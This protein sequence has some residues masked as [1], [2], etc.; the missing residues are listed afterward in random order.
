MDILDD[1]D[2]YRCKLPNLN[3]CCGQI[4]TVLSVNGIYSWLFR[5]SKI[6]NSMIE[7]IEQKVLSKMIYIDR[8]KSLNILEIRRYLCQQ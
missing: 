8:L 6:N 7:E 5:K 1:S 2:A 3:K 4:T